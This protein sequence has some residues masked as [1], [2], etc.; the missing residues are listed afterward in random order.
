MDE[1]I[2]GFLDVGLVDGVMVP[3]DDDAIPHI[4]V[5]DDIAV[6]GDTLI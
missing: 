1:D 6:I 5:D 2:E 4:S 3:C